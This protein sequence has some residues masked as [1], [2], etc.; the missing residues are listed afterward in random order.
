MDVEAVAHAS[1]KELELLGLVRKGDIL[2]MRRFCEKS[3]CDERKIKKRSLLREILEKGKSKR[4]GDMSLHGAT[5]NG[6]RGR[7]VRKVHMGWLHYNE[8]EQRY[9]SV[10]QRKGGGSRD[11]ELPLVAKCDEVIEI[12][13]K[14]FF[15]DGQ[16]IYG[17]ESEMLFGLA[18]FKQESIS[19][20]NKGGVHFTVQGYID[21]FKLS[22]IRMYLTSRNKNLANLSDS[23]SESLLKPTFGDSPGCSNSQLLPEKKRSEPELLSDSESE[24]RLIEPESNTLARNTQQHSSTNSQH[25]LQQRRNLIIQQDQAYEASLK[26]DKAKQQI[27][28]KNVSISFFMSDY[29]VQICS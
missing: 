18:N 7:A 5:N 28:R 1:D 13:R 4:K 24:V 15:K 3:D 21:R 6:K 27:S 11:C 22:R 20:V 2:N 14:L 10:R 16:S 9:M 17:P 8:E 26:A 23:D 19:D 25:L 12:G 29:V